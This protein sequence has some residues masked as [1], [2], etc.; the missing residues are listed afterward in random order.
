MEAVVFA[1]ILTLLAGLVWLFIFDMFNRNGY[2]TYGMHDH[3]MDG[4]SDDPR[5]ALFHTEDPAHHHNGSYL[6]GTMGRWP[7]V[8]THPN[9]YFQ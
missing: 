5:G 8:L 6:D 1:F 9:H 7:T 3:N 2:S 4:Y